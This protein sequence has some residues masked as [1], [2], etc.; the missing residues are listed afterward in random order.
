MIVA[1]KI[2]FSGFDLSTFSY[3]TKLINTPIHFF[4][5]VLGILIVLISSSKRDFSH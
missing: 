4:L 5:S 3:Y 1:F 2:V